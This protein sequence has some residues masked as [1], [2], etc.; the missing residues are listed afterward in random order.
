MI[1]NKT[2][3]EITKVSRT[4]PHNSL[5]IVKNEND[6]DIP[7]ERYISTEERQKIIVDPNIIL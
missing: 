4:S 7:K 6:K 5:E 3:H 2:P 1:G